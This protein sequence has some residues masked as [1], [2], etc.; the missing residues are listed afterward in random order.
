[1]APTW[2]L[3][4]QRWWLERKFEKS[5][6]IL[7]R[8]A[9]ER[10]EILNHMITL[11][12]SASDAA[13]CRVLLEKLPTSTIGSLSILDWDDFPNEVWQSPTCGTSQNTKRVLTQLIQNEINKRF[14]RGDE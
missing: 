5:N 10:R 12:N 4:L 13:S 1:M 14:E 11:W 8:I 9:E 6:Q 3:Y 2:V 7:A